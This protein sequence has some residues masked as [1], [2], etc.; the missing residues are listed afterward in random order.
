MVAIDARGV[1]SPIKSGSRRDTHMKTTWTIALDIMPFGVFAYPGNRG[2]GR[3]D[4]SA[5]PV[6][7]SP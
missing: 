2:P 5:G 6:F 1:E 4:K 3:D 7:I